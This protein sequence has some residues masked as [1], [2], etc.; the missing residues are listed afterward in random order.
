MSGANGERAGEG[1]GM[2][3]LAR[4]LAMLGAEEHRTEEVPREHKFW[5]TQPVVQP[6][7]APGQ[8]HGVLAPNVPPEQVRAEPYVLPHDFE[9]VTVNVED[10]MQLQEVYTLLTNNYVEDDEAT[11][12]FDY[13][14]EFLQWALRHP[15]YDS[16]WHVGVRVVSTG[17]LVAF[18]AGIPQELRVRDTTLRATEINFLCVHKR[19]RSKRLAPVLIKEITRRCNLRGVFQAIYTAGQVLPTPV[20]CARYYHR[21]LNADKLLDIGFSAVPRGMSREE[22]V[23]RYKLPATTAVPGLREL[24][25]DD[26]PAVARLLRRYMRRFDMAARFTD[27]EVRHMFLSGC[28]ADE[29]SRR[30]RQVT[31]SY[32]V[33]RDGRI[34]DFFSFYSL[35][36][37]VLNH[38]S[39]STLHAAYLF[40]YA[41]EA[42]FDAPL[43]AARTAAEATPS[44]L[45]EA[46]A[47]GLAPWQM[48]D[49]SALNG[50]EAAD[51][52]GVAPWEQESEAAKMRLAVRLRELM[53][54]M[55]VLAK[56]QGF[57]VVNCLSVMDNM[58]FAPTLR[59]GPGDGFL[60]FYLF[61]WRVAPIAGGL[62]VRLGEDERDPACAED[63]PRPPTTF[64]SGNGIVMV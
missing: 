29:D 38:T 25:S 3:N 4:L 9:W 8:A 16:S 28:G 26:V 15:G 30:V 32:V 34:T 41:S 1:R 14:R 43:A 51:E 21:T 47:A 27:A 49:R 39:Y 11:M 63:V 37:S 17:K 20:S 53:Q 54:D 12:R 48:S 58:L 64:G 18:I 35:P 23:A 42:V 31:W 36:S 5:R 56:R 33:E 10:A 2:H 52:A 61:N 55:L 50:A 45:S 13:S 40:Y 57:D 60:R 7:E 22:Y 59:F 24:R 6:G 19:L 44:P 62:G 46:R